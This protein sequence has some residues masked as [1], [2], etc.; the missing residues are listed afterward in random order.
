MYHWTF[1]S[2]EV[3]RPFSINALIGCSDHCRH[4]APLPN[5]GQGKATLTN[6]TVVCVI[7]IQ[8]T[9]GLF[10]ILK[11]TKKFF[12]RSAWQQ[13]CHRRP[14]RKSKQKLDISLLVM[15]PCYCLCCC[16]SAG[17]SSGSLW[18]MC[19]F[20]FRKCDFLCMSVDFRH[21]LRKKI[22]RKQKV[23]WC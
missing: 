20:L 12:R 5:N 3:E 9:E 1:H 19:A 8:E 13:P 11:T 6:S 22:F 14:K 4:H 15:S 10:C 21:C 18:Q 17:K 16:F 23:I 2:K 7:F